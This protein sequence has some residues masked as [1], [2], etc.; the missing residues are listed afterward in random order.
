MLRKM[1]AKTA[2][3]IAEHFR[4]QG[5]DVLLVVDSVTRYAQAARELA[6]AAGEPPVARGFPPSVFADLPRLLE[7]AGPGIGGRGTITGIF[8]V[9]VDGD[10]HDEPI[11][12]TVRGILDGHIVLTR[13]I[14]EQGRFPALDPL[15]SISRLAG[16]VWKPEEATLVRRLRA[17]VARFE[18]SRDLRAL[19]AYKPGADPE[20]DQAQ[21]IV[22]AIYEFMTQLPSDPPCAAVFEE[23]SQAMSRHRA[24]TE[25]ASP[26]RQGEA[27]STRKRSV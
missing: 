23:L 4:D 15:T 14:A 16:S 18:E 20:I 13:T 10:D 24:K 3:A 2:F 17:L 26:D 5:E 8:S 27:S 19:G 12:D 21:A 1:A 6:L 25:A 11:A 7:R 22:P 9:L